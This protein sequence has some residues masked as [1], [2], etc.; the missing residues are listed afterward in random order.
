M[1][2][3]ISAR[4]SE[5]VCGQWTHFSPLAVENRRHLLVERKPTYF[6]T[7]LTLPM[8]L[9][10]LC[11]LSSFRIPRDDLGDR[12]SVNMTA[13]LTAA[14]L[15]YVVAAMLPVTAELTVLDKRK[16]ASLV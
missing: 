12:L 4:L 5:P 14:A 7:H 8:Y 2:H 9:T 3:L 1:D 11:S 16:A 10:V 6:F 13:L 15:Q